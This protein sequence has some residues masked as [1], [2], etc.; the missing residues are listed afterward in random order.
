MS[1]TNRQVRR[2]RDLKVKHSDSIDIKWN[3]G[4]LE[5]NQSFREFES[6]DLNQA[7]L[8]KLKINLLTLNWIS[9][10]VP[11]CGRCSHLTDTEAQCNAANC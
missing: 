1:R 4:R 5:D 3:Y 7:V 9:L 10:I 6:L 8:E 2:M 11:K